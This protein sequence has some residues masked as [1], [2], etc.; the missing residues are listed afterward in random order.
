MKHKGWETSPFHLE[1]TMKVVDLIK[2]LVKL[3]PEMLVMKQK[4][5]EG[6]GY[7]LVRGADDD[8]YTADPTSYEVEVLRKEDIADFVEEYGGEESDYQ[9]VCVIF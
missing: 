9:Q 8:C 2:E 1:K 4:D 3:D 6:N 5:D 7:S